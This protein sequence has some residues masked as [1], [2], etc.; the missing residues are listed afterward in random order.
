MEVPTVLNRL[1]EAADFVYG[2]GRAWCDSND[3]NR[4]S[5]GVRP[6]LNGSA[7][8]SGC[9]S[10]TP[11]RFQC[12]PVLGRGSFLHRGRAANIP[13]C[14]KVKVVQ[15]TWADCQHHGP[16][17]RASSSVNCS[18]RWLL[19]DGVRVGHLSR[20]IVRRVA[21]M[22]VLW[23]RACSSHAGLD[24]LGGGETVWCGGYRHRSRGQWHAGQGCLSWDGRGVEARV[25]GTAEGG[26]GLGERRTSGGSVPASREL[27][28]NAVRRQ[29]GKTLHIRALRWF[30]RGA[31]GRNGYLVAGVRSSFGQGIRAQVRPQAV[32]A[33][34]G[35]TDWE[36]ATEAVRLAGVEPMDGADGLAEGDFP[37][38]LEWRLALTGG[39]P[40]VRQRGVTMFSRSTPAQR[41]TYALSKQRPLRPNRCRSSRARAWVARGGGARRNRHSERITGASPAGPGAMTWSIAT[42]RNPPS[43]SAESRIRILSAEI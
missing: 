23:N 10:L 35:E 4:P 16:R 34:I 43:R 12:T 22:A 9:D 7:R 26:S 33:P 28:R 21:G 5:L 11:C 13:H 29:A 24:A 14:G 17:S 39:L 30:P 19:Q 18:T 40:L 3:G 2:H 38:I 20:G 32:A 41:E 15:R 1:R 6:R 25:R 8:V 37:A 27:S 36:A 42:Y 31:A